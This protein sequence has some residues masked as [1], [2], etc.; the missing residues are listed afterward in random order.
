[1]K[2]PWENIS[3]ESQASILYP[4]PLPLGGV[5]VIGA[6]TLCYHNE[7]NKLSI[8]PPCLKQ[9]IVSCVG[10]V[11]D[12]RCLIGDVGGKLYMLF[13]ETE[14]RMN[15]NGAVP[16]DLKLEVLGEVKIILNNVYDNS[17]H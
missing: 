17:E 10:K 2:G 5:V 14:E 8:D 3:V 7:K 1:M 6:E 4:L 13:V 15:E 11:D 16:V 9:S 12:T